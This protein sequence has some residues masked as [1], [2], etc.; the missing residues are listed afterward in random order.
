MKLNQNANFPVKLNVIKL[1]YYPFQAYWQCQLR[2]PVTW[3][4]CTEPLHKWVDVPWAC[5]QITSGDRINS[6][7]SSI[8]VQMLHVMQA[9]FLMCV[10][11][12]GRLSHANVLTW[13]SGVHHALMQFF[14]LNS[15]D[16]I[17]A[18]L[19]LYIYITYTVMFV[20]CR[21]LQ[22]TMHVENSL[23]TQQKKSKFKIIPHK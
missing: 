18:C 6:K 12:H 23:D 7:D 19:H 14:P 20:F 3:L 13:T 22:F 8:E 4:K 5:T 21:P 1:L 2:L 9:V 15:S 17:V 10:M 16:N 11:R